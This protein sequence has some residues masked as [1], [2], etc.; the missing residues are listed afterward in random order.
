LPE[1][2]R[3]VMLLVVIEG[4]DYTEAAEILNVPIGTVMSR[5]SRAR[6]MIGE[7]FKGTPQS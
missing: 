5:L 2:Q 6:L 3:K 1:A 7:Q 4:F